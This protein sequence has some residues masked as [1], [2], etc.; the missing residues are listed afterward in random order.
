MKTLLEATLAELSSQVLGYSNS[1]EG[2]SPTQSYARII[3]HYLKG[4][5][6]GLERA[7]EC[8]GA[9]AIVNGGVYQLIVLL[10]RIRFNT[11]KL[12][13]DYDLFERAAAMAV[14]YP[15][16][17]GET[18][19][20]TAYALE[21]SEEH[22][23]A[24]ILYLKAANHFDS[25]GAKR[26]SVKARFNAL[27]AES[28]IDPLSKRLIPDYFFLAQQAEAVGEYGILGCAY[29]NISREYQRLG[30]FALAL[31]YSD[32][33]LAAQSKQDFGTVHY[34]LSVVHRAHL[35]FQL[36]FRDDARICLEEAQNTDFQEVKAAAAAIREMLGD[37]QALKGG[38]EQSLLYTWRERR[39]EKWSPAKSL[40]E[41]PLTEIETRLV[42]GLS[43]QPMSRLEIGEYLYGSALDPFVV[44]NRVKV[45]LNRIRGK[46]RGIIILSEGKYHLTE[47]GVAGLARGRKSRRNA[48]A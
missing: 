13:F 1:T 41:E 36:G 25:I 4:D 9:R 48:I 2:D 38:L 16:W 45:L 7:V 30:A 17:I 27:C 29:N 8:A 23:K 12:I 10:G 43:Q 40:P 46:R 21:L 26:R 44:E 20:V 19:F 33:A 24:K 15:E 47:A 35:L 18:Q 6:L 14:S 11:R 3:Y 22:E 37:R 42:E 39:N 31:K 32:A 28:C 34:Y 5:F